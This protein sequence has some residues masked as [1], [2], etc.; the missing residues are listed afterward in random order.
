[1]SVVPTNCESTQIATVLPSSAGSFLLELTSVGEWYQIKC[2]SETYK[3]HVLPDVL[4]VCAS[5]CLPVSGL[6]S[7][8]DRKLKTYLDLYIDLYKVVFIL[9]TYFTCVKNLQMSGVTLTFRTRKNL[10]GDMVFR[11]LVLFVLQF[12]S[13]SFLSSSAIEKSQIFKKIC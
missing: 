7:A 1:M 2:R 10:L 13:L 5:F 3:R 8:S 12:A 6:I 9:G 11:K 4:S